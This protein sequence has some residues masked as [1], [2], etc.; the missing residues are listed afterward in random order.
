M[1]RDKRGRFWYP[2]SGYS[3]HHLFVQ[4]LTKA[5]KPIVV[6][7]TET[8][9]T[10]K[11]AYVVQFAGLKLTP[12]NGRYYITDKIN[13]LIKPPIPMP[14]GASAVN[15]ITDDMLKDKPTEDF[16]VDAFK[17]FFSGSLITGYNHI[18]FDN[19]MIDHMYER[20]MGINFV[21][22]ENVDAL[23]MA[24][25]L[26]DRAE[27]Q[28]FTLKSISELYGI[29]P[30]ENEQ[31]HDAL[32]DTKVTMQTLWALIRDYVDLGLDTDYLA[33]KN[34]MRLQIIRM[35]VQKF[36][37]ESNYIIIDV[38]APDGRSG[39]FRYEVYNKRFVEMQGNLMQEA[40]MERFILDADQF[41]GGDV[42][43]Y[44]DK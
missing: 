25:G 2:K 39:Q 5:E 24:R 29:K 37:K 19:K 18:G 21:P 43:K 16:C 14:E 31:L 40:D 30:D 17:K 4:T 36:S 3:M 11:T 35:L 20:T 26:V 1:L 42:A 9:G 32:A 22:D 7:D 34:K 27:C 10:G 33:S 28:D 23:I 38:Y 41:A 15:H 12:Q 6:Y 13:Q 44:K 8:T